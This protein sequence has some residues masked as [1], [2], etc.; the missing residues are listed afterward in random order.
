MTEKQLLRKRIAAQKKQYTPAQL[1]GWSSSLLEKL[2]SHPLFRSAQTLFLYYS[3]SDEVQTHEFIRKW[4]QEKRIVLPVVSGD[5]LELR[6][7]TDTQSLKKGCFGI[8]EPTDG[9]LAKE[10]EIDLALIPGVAFDRLGNRLGRGKGYYD[11]TLKR[12][13][14]AYRIGICFDFQIQEKV[15]TEENDCRMDEVWTENGPISKKQYPQ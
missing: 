3:L 14:H 9:Q 1:S 12:L 6:Y 13:G 7:F 11:R 15:P 4:N 8:G 10:N 2:E 5:N